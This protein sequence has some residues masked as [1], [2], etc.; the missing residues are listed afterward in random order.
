MKIQEQTKVLA[1]T[2]VKSN[3]KNNNNNNHETMPRTNQQKKE[4][5]NEQSFAEQVA[6]LNA[7]DMFNGETIENV[8]QR[9]LELC[10]TYIGGT[11]CQATGVEEIEVKRIAGGVTNQLFKV[12][13]RQSVSSVPNEIYPE[14][15]PRVVAIKL[16]Q[17]KHLRNFDAKT[18]SERLNDIIILTILS[19]V[20]IGPKVYGIFNDGVI[21]AFIEVSKPG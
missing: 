6:N 3:N 1:K 4:A 2:E 17:S 12:A 18:E 8:E 16:Y 11:W 20:E 9:C 15:E 10:Q 7:E 14:D 21:Q 13:L 5:N 19:E